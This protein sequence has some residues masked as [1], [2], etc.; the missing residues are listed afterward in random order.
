MFKV[1]VAFI[2]L[3][4]GHRQWHK[5]CVGTEAYQADRRDTFCRHMVASGEPLVIL[6]AQLDARVA[7]NQHVTVPGGI[8][9]YAG[10]P[11]RIADGPV[12]GTVC[13]IDVVPRKFDEEDLEALKD[14]AAVVAREIELRQLA[15][16]DPLTG[17]LSRRAFQERGLQAARLAVRHEQALSCIAIDIDHF[18]QINDAHGHSAGDKVL[19]AVAKA[20]EGALRATDLVGR[21]GG[22]EFSVLLPGTS[23]HGALEAA[24]KLLRA[25]RVVRVDLASITLRVT[26]SIGLASLEPFSGDMNALLDRADEA[27]HTAKNAGRDRMVVWQGP[28]SAQRRVL[29]TRRIVFNDRFSTIDC[30]IRSLG[31][32]GAGFDVWNAFDVPDRFTLEIGPHSQQR[33]CKV[34][35]RADKHVEVD[36]I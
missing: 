17:L 16:T 18:K 22:E 36:F 33:E 24:E 31:D 12:I 28:Q 34:M 7:D 5:A 25:I 2:S 20:C 35:S 15:G 11:L 14:L 29:K 21:V 32:K 8:R 27:L 30:T 10:V 26:A 3:M 4:D 19:M 1:P 9:F 6:D 23:R 13:A